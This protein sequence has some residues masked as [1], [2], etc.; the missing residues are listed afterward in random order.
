MTKDTQSFVDSSQ[1]IHNFTR[2]SEHHTKKSL[3]KHFVRPN[4]DYTLS[5]FTVKNHKIAKP[6]LEHKSQ[7]F[8]LSPFPSPHLTELVT[9]KICWAS[10]SSCALPGQPWL[11]PSQRGIDRY[12]LYKSSVCKYP[13]K[14]LHSVNYFWRNLAE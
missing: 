3:T 10:S 13:M 11:F 2:Y 14:W 1:T 5:F 9:L 7:K 12:P 6:G 4:Q 8:Y